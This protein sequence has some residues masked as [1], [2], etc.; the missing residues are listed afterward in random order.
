MTKYDRNQDGRKDLL[1]GFRA[2]SPQVMPQ[3]SPPGKANYYDRIHKAERHNI[4]GKQ[5]PTQRAKSAGMIRGYASEANLIP[6]GARANP[7]TQPVGPS[8]NSSIKKQDY[9]E[10]RERAHSNKYY[11]GH[12]GHGDGRRHGEDPRR[13][14][15]LYGITEEQVHGYGNNH[16]P[17]FIHQR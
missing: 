6:V 16:P 9:M 3:N 1:P 8:F 11:G 15:H 4:G 10:R 2:Q 5:T 17:P 14:D 13:R 12:G 7:S